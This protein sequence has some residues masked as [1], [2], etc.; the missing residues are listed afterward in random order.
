[1]EKFNT[2]KSIP[3]YMPI[4]NIDTDMIIPKQFLKTIKRT[5][6]GINL[7]YEMR[8]DEKGNLIKDFT[9]N[10]KPF[11]KS[12]ILLTGKNFGCG[13]SREHAPWALLDFGIKCVI[14][15]SFADIFYNNCF[16]N[17]IL[18]IVIDEKKI[19]ELAEYSKREQSIEIK[20]EPQEIFFGNKSFKFDLDSF[21]KKCLIEGLDDIALSL[22]KVANI[23]N[24]ETIIQKTKPWLTDND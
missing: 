10:K 8:Y 6:L 21:K 16:K 20:I 9:F 2:L 7:F 12:K 17:G 15:P 14:A 18:P 23:Q 4:L 13:S 1:M 5:G 3:A 11:D 22:E 19:Q 24:Y